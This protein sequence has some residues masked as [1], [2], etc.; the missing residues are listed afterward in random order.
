VGENSGSGCSG[1]FEEAAT[2]THESLP[3]WVRRRHVPRAQFA[4]LTP[5]D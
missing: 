5:L 1:D 4:G 3:S 2:I